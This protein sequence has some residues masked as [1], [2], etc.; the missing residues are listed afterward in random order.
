M[1]W[2]SG[3]MNGHPG[4][5]LAADLSKMKNGPHNAPELPHLNVNKINGG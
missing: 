1:L 3:I 5:E 4:I 2:A